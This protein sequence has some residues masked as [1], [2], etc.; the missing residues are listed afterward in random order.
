MSA[1]KSRR[2]P[3][4][5][6]RRI[7][8]RDPYD[9]VLIVTEGKKT[10]PLYFNELVEYYRLNTANVKVLPG[11]LGTDPRSVVRAAL[12]ERDDEVRQGDRYDRVYC[13]FDR[14]SHAHFQS[15]SER[16]ESKDLRLA[17][18][19]PCFEFWLLLHFI[20]S[21]RPYQ[22]SQG[23]S[24]CDNCIS[25]LKKH[26]DDYGKATGGVFH[27][28]RHRLEVAKDHARQAMDD[29]GEHGEPNPSTEVHDLVEYL[30]RLKKVEQPA[31]DSPEA[32]G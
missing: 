1:R 15:A 30:Q 2:S 5:L 12:K 31:L 9:R 19:W 8:T 27:R 17:R 6:R 11:N 4:S 14:D 25:D 22:D 23:K 7:R 18:S 20:Y 16:A 26:M 29:V 24:P 21:R 28:L 3:R 32:L 13:V 10:E